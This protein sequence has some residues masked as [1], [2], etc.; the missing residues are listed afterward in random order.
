MSPAKLPSAAAPQGYVVHE[1]RMVS[2][3]EARDLD[4]PGG[5]SAAPYLTAAEALLELEV[6]PEHLVAEEVRCRIVKLGVAS[7]R[8]DSRPESRGHPEVSAAAAG[9]GA[10]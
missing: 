4:A 9:A 6:R 10:R 5:S 8:V 7:L 2:D 3:K 1:M